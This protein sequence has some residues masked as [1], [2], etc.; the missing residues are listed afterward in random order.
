MKKLFKLLIIFSFILLVGC[1]KKQENSKVKEEN[2]TYRIEYLEDKSNSEKSVFKYSVPEE[3][4][5]FILK[6][7]VYE[8]GEESSQQIILEDDLKKGEGSIEI[9]ELEEENDEISIHFLVL[10]SANNSISAV[11]QYPLDSSTFNSYGANANKTNDLNMD[12]YAYRW[13]SSDK[14]NTLESAQI[15]FDKSFDF[16]KDMK[17]DETI[18]L[19]IGEFVGK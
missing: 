12:L 13:L 9:R 7:I 8:N 3:N 18:V 5:H 2:K 16:S 15:V 17:N 11:S 1:Q 10:D 19:W 6:E 4:L 14:S